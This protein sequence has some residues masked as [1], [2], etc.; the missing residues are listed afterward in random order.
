[1]IVPVGP[2]S[3]E[4]WATQD[5]LGEIEEARARRPQLEPRLL[6]TRLRRGTRSSAELPVEAGQELKVTALESR[7]GYRVAYSE[8][9][10][11]G[12]TV[13][14]LGDRSARQELAALVEEVIT[15][16]P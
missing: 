3:V 12:L 9:L 16:L 6:W 13:A 5:L 1:V 2:S 11:H 15:L 4:L 8:A 14:E 10:G 7:L